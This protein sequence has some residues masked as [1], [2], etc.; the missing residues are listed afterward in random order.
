MTAI[1]GGKAQHDQLASHK[2]AALL[3]GGMLP[4]ASVY[5]AAM[6][7]PRD[8]LRRRPHLRRQRAAL[9]A[10]VHTTKSQSNLPELGKKLAYKANRD[11]VA[12]RFAAAA[13]QKT[14]EVALALLTDDDA[15]LKALERS[16]RKTAKPHAANTLSRLQTVPGMGKMRSRVRLDEIPRIDRF[17]RVQAFA[18]DARLVKGRTESGGN[19][20]GTSGNRIGHAHLQW[21]VSEAAPLVLRSNPQGQKLL[22]RLEKNHDTGKALSMLAPTL[23]RAVYCMRK[24]QVAFDLEMFRQTAGSRAGAPGA[25]LDSCGMSLS[26]AC[27]QPSPAASLNAK[28]RRGRFSRS[29]RE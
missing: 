11:G 8:L 9:L 5:P 26:H 6:R 10:Q 2:I 19:R 22:G 13:V 25:S 15:R 18:S 23:G 21:A 27:A 14:I 4:Q 7:A 17:P 16:R 28:A 12:E 1:D 24:R 20:L 29:P 3:R